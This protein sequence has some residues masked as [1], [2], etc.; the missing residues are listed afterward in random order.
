M[1]V[2]IRSKKEIER[3]KA[4]GDVV[5]DVLRELRQRARVGV[6]TA[7][8]ADISDN[9]IASAGAIALFKGVPNPQAD[10]DFPASICTS[11]NEQVVHGIPGPVKLRDGDIISIDCG[12]KL[13]G[14]CGDAAITVA[15]G[16]LEPETQRLVD[17]TREV[18]DIA[19]NEARAGRLWSEV[20]GKMQA[21]AEKEGFGVVREYVGHGIGRRMHEDPKLPNFVSNQLLRHDL[22]L[23][24]GM[25]FAVE[26]MVTAGTYKVRVLSD[27]WTVVTADNKPAAH[28][29]KTIAINDGP[30]EVL[31]CWD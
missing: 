12:A 27:G 21:H 22:M 16:G 5:A 1:A 13:R 11:I 30:A 14:Y 23:R 7:E 10:F 20:A 6:T 24:K 4:A 8:L 26:P 25:V 28:F 9:M 17:I 3:I 29:E 2:A 18:L 19:I 31:T 15:V